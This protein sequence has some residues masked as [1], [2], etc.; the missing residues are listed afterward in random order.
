MHWILFIVDRV[1]VGIRTVH[2]C[3]PL[4][5]CLP[6][7]PA[8]LPWVLARLPWVPAYLPWVPAGLACLGAGRPCLLGCASE[9]FNN[10]QYH[11]QW[12]Q[13]HDRIPSQPKGHFLI[14]K[15][16]EW[17][18]VEWPAP[19]KRKVESVSVWRRPGWNSAEE[20]CVI[21]RSMNIRSAWAGLGLQLK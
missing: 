13:Q 16:P 4:P 5:A 7:V 8:C 19:D 17:E 6:W 18:D 15:L 20:A 11:L 3:L 21:G 1:R 14:S 12:P 9:C 10:T 2:T